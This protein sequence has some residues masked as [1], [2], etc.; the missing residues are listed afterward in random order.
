M[1][2]VGRKNRLGGCCTITLNALVEVTN[3]TFTTNQPQVTVSDLPPPYCRG[4]KILLRQQEAQNTR[5]YK[6]IYI[7]AP[8]LVLSI[9]IPYLFSVQCLSSNM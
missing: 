2:S 5:L 4:L 8:T 9:C 7:I 6:T 1:A 3:F